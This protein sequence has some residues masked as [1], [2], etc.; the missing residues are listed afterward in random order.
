FVR[1][2]W[3]ITTLISFERCLCIAMPL[4]VKQIVTPRS[5]TC[6]LL[7]MVFIPLTGMYPVLIGR[8]IGDVSVKNVT[9]T[10]FYYAENGQFLN[11]VSE[12]FSVV[13]Q[14]SSYIINA[15]CAAVIIIQL[16][17]DSKW[18][19]QSSS[20]GK[21]VNARVSRDKRITKMV[22]FI[23]SLFILCSLASCISYILVV[24]HVPGYSNKFTDT[25]YLA[26]REF[27][28]SLEAINSSGN[29][30]VYYAMSSKYR[31]VFNQL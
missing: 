16:N 23:S 29:N 31:S 25:T 22:A 15:I 5:T 17:I 10:G 27:T 30:L 12:I 8:R 3:W 7:L 26:V 6:V 21:L 19:N 13:M 2:A 9:V 14:F 1:I 28:I 18:R 4:K 11:K 24:S 20:S